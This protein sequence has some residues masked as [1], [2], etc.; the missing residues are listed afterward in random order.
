[1]TA[2]AQLLQRRFRPH[3]LLQQSRTLHLLP[4]Q[5]ATYPEQLTMVN[6]IMDNL[7]M[8][9]REKAEAWF[10]RVWN[11]RHWHEIPDYIDT[12]CS[13]R[14]FG[15]AAKLAIGPDGFFELMKQTV[16]LLPDIL[17]DVVHIIAEGPWT[18]THWVARAHHEKQEIVVE[19]IA[20]AQWREGRMVGG[21][22]GFDP[23][24]FQ[25]LLPR[26]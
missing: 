20:L 1:M 10:R 9:N 15:A 24:K 3:P 16:D 12:G 14:H 5:E 22:D 13:A 7:T 4:P 23:K 21:M 18:A 6:L 8:D 17:F 25:D 26:E 2:A 11:E 19:G